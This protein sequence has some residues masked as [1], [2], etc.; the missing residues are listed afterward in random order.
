MDAPDPSPL[1]MGMVETTR[2]W[3]AGIEA[4][5]TACWVRVMAMRKGWEGS[6]APRLEF[7]LDIRRFDGHL[8]GLTPGIGE[9]IGGGPSFEHRDRDRGRP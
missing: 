3:Q 7:R 9:D 4:A 1:A 5:P 8:T 2:I 6:S